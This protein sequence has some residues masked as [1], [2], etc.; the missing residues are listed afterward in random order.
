ME[1]VWCPHDG[2]SPCCCD[3]SSI[4]W[5]CDCTC[6][7]C[8]IYSDGMLIESS[9]DWSSTLLRQ[10]SVLVFAAKWQSIQLTWMHCINIWNHD[11][12]SGGMAINILS[13]WGR[14]MLWMFSQRL[15]DCMRSWLRLISKL[16]SS[17][18]VFRSKSLE[19]VCSQL[20]P[21]REYRD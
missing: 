7:C 10:T 9:S 6:C 18:M 20:T 12:F 4:S 19:S 8:S 5:T 15:D 2:I 13:S 17:S 11:F 16:L 1:G 14:K 21:L 3:S